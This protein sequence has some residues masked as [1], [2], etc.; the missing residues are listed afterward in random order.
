MSAPPS[1]PPLSP[2]GGLLPVADCDAPTTLKYCSSTAMASQDFGCMIV[3]AVRHRGQ[4]EVPLP[5]PVS[6]AQERLADCANGRRVTPSQLRPARFQ[7]PQPVLEVPAFKSPL[8]HGHVSGLHATKA[9]PTGKF[10][11]SRF[12]HE[13]LSNEHATYM[14]ALDDIRAKQARAERGAANLIQN[15]WRVFAVLRKKAHKAQSN[16]NV[17]R[18]HLTRDTRSQLWGALGSDLRCADWALSAKMRASLDEE[19]KEAAAAIQKSFRGKTA[20]KAL[21]KAGQAT[22][23]AEA[24]GGSGRASPKSFTGNSA[25]SGPCSSRQEARPSL[26]RQQSRDL[27]RVKAEERTSAAR[28]R[29]ALEDEALERKQARVYAEAAAEAMAKSGTA[30]SKSPV[31]KSGPAHSLRRKGTNGAANGAAN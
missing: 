14:K 11:V 9:G 6:M 31:R 5:L 23:P 1:M 15:L 18:A 17:I 29:R 24:D 25:N 10:R 2:S 4:A 20:R 30:K 12:G 27:A 28:A 13:V 8:M 7:K 21:G 16:K 22:Q 19:A 26:S 3:T